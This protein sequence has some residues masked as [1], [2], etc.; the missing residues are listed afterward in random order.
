M[1][2]LFDHYAQEDDS[3]KLKLDR[4]P[5]LIGDFAHLCGLILILYDE[6]LEGGALR[7]SNQAVLDDFQQFVWRKEHDK[8]A[9][10]IHE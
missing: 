3:E 10:M 7:Q 4:V 1:R 2:E 6:Y 9:A 5:E 8:K